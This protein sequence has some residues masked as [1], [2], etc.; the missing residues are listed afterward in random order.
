MAMPNG[1]EWVAAGA[2]PNACS[3]N[4]I[5]CETSESS[6][7]SRALTTA[8]LG[9]GKGKL[10]GHRYRAAAARSKSDEFFLFIDPGQ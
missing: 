6:H 3:V 5:E 9:S 1:F 4:V 2:L 7:L 10:I 8:V